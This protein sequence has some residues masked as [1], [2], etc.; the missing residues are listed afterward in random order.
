M[1]INNQASRPSAHTRLDDVKNGGTY[2][3]SSTTFRQ[4]Q[5]NDNHRK[6]FADLTGLQAAAAK[7]IDELVNGSTPEKIISNAKSFH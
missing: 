4:Y 7:S 6:V 1:T 2:G 5:H 3:N